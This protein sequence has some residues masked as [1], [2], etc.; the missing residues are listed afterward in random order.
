M[1]GR[2]LRT[3]WPATSPATGAMLG[4]INARPSTREYLEA[5]HGHV[6]DTDQLQ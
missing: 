3:S 1:P 6:W 5:K 2:A 4:E